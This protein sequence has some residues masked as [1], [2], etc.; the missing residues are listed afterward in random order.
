MPPNSHGTTRFVNEVLISWGKAAKKEGEGCIVGFKCFGFKGKKTKKLRDEN[1]MKGSWKD[2]MIIWKSL[3]CIYWK[4]LEYCLHSKDVVWLRKDRDWRCFLCHLTRMGLCRAQNAWRPF[5]TEMIEV[6]CLLSQLYRGC[7]YVSD[8]GSR[9]V[10]L[11]PAC[12]VS[13][14]F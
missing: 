7:F 12:C 5:R 13:Y 6:P 8:I 11:T 9:Y 4:L 10:Y 14:G 2:E 3:V 1:L